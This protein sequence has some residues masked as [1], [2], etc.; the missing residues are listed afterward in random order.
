MELLVRTPLHFPNESLLGYLLRVSEANGYDTPWHVFR[1]AG[2]NQSEMQS[3]NLPLALLAPVLNS[4]TEEL[5]SLAYVSSGPAPSFKILGHDLGKSGKENYLRL[6]RPAF[7][8]HCVQEKGYIEAFW[9]LSAAVACPDHHC[10]PIR[11]CH[12]CGE[13][14]RWLRPGLLRCRCGANLSDA[15]AMG[16]STPTVELMGL[17]RAKLSRTPLREQPNTSGFPVEALEP[18]PMQAMMR[19]LLSLGEQCLQSRGVNAPE[20]AAAFVAASTVLSDWPRGYHRTLVEVG[21]HLTKDGFRGVGLRKQF[22]PFYSALFKRKKLSRH[23]QFLKDEFVNFGLQH[24]GAATV[25]AKLQRPELVDDARYISKSQ[26]ARQ[27]GLTEPKLAQMLADGTIATKTIKTGKN[28]RV[29]VDLKHSKPP[30]ASQG[31]LIVRAAADR[32]GLPVSVLEHLRDSGVYL[33]KPRLGHTSSWHLDDVEEFLQRG[34]ALA[35]TVAGDAPTVA[36]AD[37]MRIKLRDPAAKGDIVAALFDGRL[38]VRGCSG[39]HLGGLILDT[40]EVEAFVSEKRRTVEEDTFSISEAAAVTALDSKVVSS[41]VSLGLLE[42]AVR[43]GRPR[44]TAASVAQFSATYVVIAKLAN[45]LETSARRLCRFCRENG[46]DMVEIPQ[47]KTTSA[48]WILPLALKDRLIETW[49]LARQAQ[50][51]GATLSAPELYE[52]KM[53]TYLTRL[54][55]DQEL[56]PRRAGAPNKVVIARACGFQRDVL[57]R[58]KNVIALLDKHEQREREGTRILS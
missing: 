33:T 53:R 50:Q 22:E 26:Y 25:D 30:V 6:R 40:A 21:E 20:L 8:P 28:S 15:S 27:H 54:Q 10:P 44:I 31:L 55:E 48:M 9:D 58:H 1:L 17:L 43:D 51:R 29:V 4:D 7:C 14:I 37:V 38:S 39:D 42:S 56:L 13:T 41:A 11:H 23:I 19:M 46:F 32:L 52:E 34:Q 49:D 35:R 24:W 57:Y 47:P 5:A 45:D 18:I 3:P 36:L 2:L 16:M 12:E